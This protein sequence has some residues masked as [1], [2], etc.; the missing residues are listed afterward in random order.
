MNPK[1]LSAKTIRVGAAFATKE[2]AIR[3]C[4][5]LLL[6]AGH[7]E[8]AYID[9]MV[10]RD[11]LSTTYVGNN[12]AVPHG[13][14]DARAFIKN[15]GVAIIQVPAGVDFGAGNIA[16]ILVGIAALG[17]EHMDLLTEIALVCADDASLARLI[18]AVDAAT[19]LAVITGQGRP[20]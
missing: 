19:I 11:C 20:A 18:G 14:K 7:I 5:Q 12:V 8:A 16:H 4:G 1:L 17:D 3:A 15:T 9:K 2:E 6:A 10:E 13:T